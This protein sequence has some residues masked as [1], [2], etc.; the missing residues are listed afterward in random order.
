MGWRG[1]TTWAQTHKKKSYLRKRHLLVIE[2]CDEHVKQGEKNITDLLESIRRPT[3]LIIGELWRIL[4][5]MRQLK[6]V[7]ESPYTG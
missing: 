5:K 3:D 1:V 4:F 2:K 7:L 6:R